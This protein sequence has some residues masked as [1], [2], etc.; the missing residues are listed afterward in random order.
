[1][2][3]IYD[4]HKCCAEKYVQVC[5]SHRDLSSRFDVK[6]L[7]HTR[8][9]VHTFAQFFYQVIAM[10]SLSFLLSKTKFTRKAKTLQ[11]ASLRGINWNFLLKIISDLLYAKSTFKI[12]KKESWEQMSQGLQY[13][14]DVIFFLKKK[15]VMSKNI[16]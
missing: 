15:R 16:Y 8:R 11:V 3:G 5:T 14:F 4:D 2:E 10:F 9:H 13:V 12:E 1:M 7:T 6:S